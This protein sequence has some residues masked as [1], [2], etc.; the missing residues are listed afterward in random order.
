MC[1]QLQKFLETITEFYWT[2]SFLLEIIAN[3]QMRHNKTYL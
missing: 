1:N 3:F 2:N